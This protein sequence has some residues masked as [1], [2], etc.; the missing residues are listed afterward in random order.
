M[1]LTRR[2]FLKQT[3][4]LTVGLPS[5]TGCGGRLTSPEQAASPQ[6]S[7]I[8]FP[9]AFR[10]ARTV[11]IGNAV[12]DG[13]PAAEAESY[14]TWSVVVTVGRAGIAPGGGI[15]VGLRHATNLWSPI[16][17]RDPKADG[18]IAVQSPQHAPATI[19]I[20]CGG[21]GPLF[22]RYFP[23]QIMVE[24]IL[25]GEGLR[26]GE[27]ARITFGDRSGGSKGLKL[28]PFTERR[29]RFMTYV[30]VWGNGRF[31]PIEDSPTLEITAGP[32]VKLVALAPSDAVR[33]DTT[34]CTLR[35]EDC[36]GNVASTYRGTVRIQ[37]SGE[38][39]AHEH[40][41]TAT[42]AGVYRFEGLAA[43]ARSP[44][45]WEATDGKLS[46]RSNPVVV[47]DKPPAQLVLW[48]DI[49]GHSECSDGR[50]TP[51]EY[52]A[53]GRRVAALDFAALTDH[54]FELPESVWKAVQQATNAAYIPGQ[55]T[56]L[57]A[58][59]WSGE[60]QCGGDHNVYFS[61]DQ[62]PIYRSRWEG[63]ENFQWAHETAGL[64]P[65]LPSLFRLLKRDHKVGQVL[66]IPHRG[67]RAANPQWYDP[68]LERLIEASSEHFRSLPWA[69]EFLR[70]GY[71]LGLM[72]S[73]DSHYG[74]A[75][76]GFLNHQFYQGRVGEAQV[77]VLAEE[78]TRR[79]VFSALYNRRCY[80]TTGD[81]I[82]VDFRVNGATMGSEIRAS[83]PPSIEAKVIGT[84]AL[85]QVEIIKDG[86]S[87]YQVKPAAESVEFV[88]RDADYPR[89]RSSYYCLKVVQT[90]DEEA[91]SSPVWVDGPALADGN[92]HSN[93]SSRETRPI[94]L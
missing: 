40:R 85:R 75:G 39:N 34:W 60:H 36:R 63:P 70:R 71:R 45:R 50:G 24:A 7:G 16:Q 59:E 91:W 31:L 89:A 77:A 67:G 11:G 76:Y 15:R 73:A 57:Q 14:G 2:Q 56:T 32:A 19:Q 9:E 8:N 53:H 65:D 26:P 54:D 81:R 58:Y 23:Y 92:D 49:H 4:L 74:H 51:A 28:Q 68:D 1:T 80:A 44:V 13:P 22:P 72:A 42:D 84:A 29:F 6:V 64:A 10:L 35:A 86:R 33:G 25:G 52:Y 82:V 47:H 46:A 62:G 93:N 17:N 3:G 38:S 18:L 69:E 12:L 21:M 88:W 30:D 41:F 37:S 90:N 94:L 66:V 43:P 78:N 55:F 83:T 5:L 79:G 87:V 61:G 48:G 20:F 27:T